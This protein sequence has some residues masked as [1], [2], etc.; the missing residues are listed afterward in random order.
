MLLY[1]VL[2]LQDILGYAA[3]ATG[4]RLMVISGGM[5]VAA[6]V[7]GRLSSTCRSGS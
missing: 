7:A 6:T 4:V 2:Y 5:S 1:L 3:L